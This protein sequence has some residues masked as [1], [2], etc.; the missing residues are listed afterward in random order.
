MGFKLSRNKLFGIKN[1]TTQNTLSAPAVGDYM[2]IQDATFKIGKNTIERDYK[3]GTLDTL[4]SVT[5]ERWAEMEVTVELRNSSS[6][7]YP[8]LQSLFTACGCTASMIS[9]KMTIEPV[10]IAPALMFSPAISSTV[11]VHQDGI[12]YA[13]TGVV[14]TAKGTLEAGKIPMMTFSLKGLYSASHDITNPVATGLLTSA[15][16][17]VQEITLA[18][19][20]Y[21]PIAVSKVDFDLGTETAMLSDVNSVNAVY[22]FMMTGRKPTITLN[23]VV[24]TLA[25]H[26]AITAMIAGT[27]YSISARIGATPGTGNTVTLTFPQVQ[28]TD[29]S[30]EDRNGV[31]AYTITGKCNGSGNNSYKIELD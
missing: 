23:P 20:A 22:G 21:T 13:S 14:G 29:V 3:R 30:F 6:L 27:E 5:A 19:G 10:S 12:R 8:E 17:I 4:A 1:E 28:Y 16:P 18:V 24:D 9:S 2:T 15:A 25:N 7:G 11:Y 31:L 26:D